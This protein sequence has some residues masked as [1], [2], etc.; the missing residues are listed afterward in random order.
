MTKVQI[1]KN[2]PAPTGA[3]NGGKYPWNEMGVGDSFA[4]HA[5]SKNS[6]TAYSYAA[7]ANARYAPK[8]FRGGYIDGVGRIWRIA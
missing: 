1:D 4:I 7:Q 5:A 3:Y 6:T 8:K 2:I